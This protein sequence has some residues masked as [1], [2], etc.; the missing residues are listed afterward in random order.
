VLIGLLVIRLPEMY[1][2][3]VKFRP[4]IVAGTII[5]ALLLSRVGAGAWRGV[6]REPVVRW[7]SLY[8]FAIVAAVPFALWPGGAVQILYL[9]PFLGLL[10]VTMML[11]PP[12]RQTLDRIIAW[13]VVLGGI[14]AAYV[15][16]A[17][18]IVMDSV[19]GARLGG[20]GTYDPNDI[21]AVMV[22]VLQLALG[23]ALRERGRWRWAGVGCALIATT[24][25]LRTGSRGGTVALAVSTLVLLLAQKPGRFF[26][27]ATAV[28]LAAPLAWTFGPESFRV[29]TLSLFALQND[30]T[31][32]ADA[33]RWQ[34]WKRGLGYFAQ[35]P[36]I[37]VGPN[38][39]GIREG[40][41]YAG[42]GRSGAWLTTHNTY[43][44]VLVEVGIFGGI[45]LCGLI[46]VAVRGS[47][48]LWRRPPPSAPD[49]LYRPEVFAAIA[50]FLT[51]AFFLSHAYTAL[52]LF[53]LTL[54]A[55]A[56][57]VG[58]VESASVSLRARRAAVAH[59]TSRTGNVT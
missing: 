26:M 14:Y 32:Q 5:G 46:W 47:V 6:F 22:V 55:Y 41:F 34:I 38:N 25:V 56:G 49:R 3:I 15:A 24:V 20:T 57:R 50:A 23:M 12:T 18:S 37:G 27:L 42:V 35:R 9:L 7:T 8:L 11:S 1:L 10:V 51:S 48:P 19:G 53:V 54:G 4:S 28:A 29:R 21:A 31:F 45:A 44:Q 40:Q 17:G 59:A 43:I 13:T 52:L 58:Q 30:Y 33:G 39:Y 36:I 2:P 16:V